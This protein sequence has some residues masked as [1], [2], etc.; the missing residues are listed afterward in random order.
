MKTSCSFSQ[1]TLV[2]M[3]TGELK[4]ISSVMNGDKVLCGYD[5]KNCYTCY[6]VVKKVHRVICF[7]FGLIEIGGM[8]RFYVSSQQ[9]LLI[10]NN[11]MFVWCRANR[12]SKLVI[13]I[14]NSEEVQTFYELEL[15]G[16][17]NYFVSNADICV[18]AFVQS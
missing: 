16:F 6:A 18:K 15:D 12:I 7:D 13:P 14:E 17:N 3:C 5:L 10:C 8:E 11:G 9:L 2:R 4:K 1:N